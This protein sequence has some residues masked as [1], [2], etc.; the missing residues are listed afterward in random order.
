[1]LEREK[2]AIIIIS[3]ENDWIIEAIKLYDSNTVNQLLSLQRC[4][5]F[6]IIIIIII[7]D[8]T[9]QTLSW[10]NRLHA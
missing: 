1:M 2:I 3:A 8:P 5:S 4:D 6:S 9:F 7:V 10:L